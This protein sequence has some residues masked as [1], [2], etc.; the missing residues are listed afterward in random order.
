MI[1]IYEI[2]TDEIER[3]AIKC[4]LSTNASN[5]PACSDHGLYVHKPRSFP[6]NLAPKM[7][8]RQQLFSLDYGFQVKNSYNRNPNQN[9][10]D[11]FINE[12]A[13]ANRKKGFYTNGDPNRRRLDSFLY[14]AAQNEL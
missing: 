2:S 10:A 14:E 9:S 5:T 3:A 12:S 13:P 6:P 7:R 1:K 4:R 11:F 8:E